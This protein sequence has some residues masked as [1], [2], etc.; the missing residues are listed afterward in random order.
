MGAGSTPA[1]PAIPNNL[2]TS[3]PS[4]DGK[5][6]PNDNQP[7][8]HII[9]P[10]SDMA[11]FAPSPAKFAKLEGDYDATIT[12]VTVM[13]LPPR[14]QK[15]KK[16][17]RKTKGG[18]GKAVTKSKPSKPSKPGAKLLSLKFQLDERRADGMTY[19]VEKEIRGQED[20]DSKFGEFMMKILTDEGSLNQFF[21][22]YR[23]SMLLNRRC[24]LKLKEARRKGQSSFKI[25]DVLPAKV[26]TPAFTYTGTTREAVTGPIKE[27]VHQLAAAA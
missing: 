11:L 24:A 10:D 3:S 2:G 12:G 13:E 7:I 4:K 18:K 22:T 8:I 6:K 9:T 16:N 15:P 26:S 14:E 27:P 20:R 19:T 23:L 25:L 17:G 21:S 5:G 1:A